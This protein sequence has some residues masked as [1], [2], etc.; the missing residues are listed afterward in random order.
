[1]KHDK[2]VKE[3]ILEAMSSDQCASVYRITRDA[4]TDWATTDRNLGRLAVEG[5]VICEKGLWRKT[6]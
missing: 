1:M 3:R 4:Q 6:K 5:K 2:H